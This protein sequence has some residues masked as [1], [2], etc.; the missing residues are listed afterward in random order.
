MKLKIITAAAPK[1]RMVNNNINN[2]LDKLCLV[3]I[4]IKKSMIKAKIMNP[5]PM[6]TKPATS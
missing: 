2:F 4:L 1:I 5:I 6:N 3:F